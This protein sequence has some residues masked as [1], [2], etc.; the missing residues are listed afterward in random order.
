MSDRL[1]LIIANSKF[2]DPKL[3]RLVAPSHDAKALA[4][5]AFSA[6]LAAVGELAQ[7]SQ[8]QNRALAAAARVELERLSQEDENPAVRGAA[9]GAL[10][11]FPT[12]VAAPPPVK[13]KKP[14]PRPDALTITSPIHLELVRVPAGEFLM[15]S[16]PAKDKEADADEQS[17]HRVHVSE[18]HIGKYPLTNAQYAAFVRAMKRGAPAHWQSGRSFRLPT[19]A[20]WEKAARGADGRITSGGTHR[21]RTSCATLPTMSVTPHRWAGIRPGGIVPMAAPIWPAMCGSGLA[22]SVDPNL[23]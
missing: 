11:T 17:Q 4:S 9:A 8:G 10:G 13:I 3:S 14:A 15:G 16:D 5:G 2:D 18:F 21:S 1:A 22:V 20:E 12:K 19:E 7:L 6:R 23:V